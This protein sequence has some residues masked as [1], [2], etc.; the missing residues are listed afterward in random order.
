MAVDPASESP[1][2]NRRADRARCGCKI[3]GNSDLPN[4]KPN[5]FFISKGP[6]Q[7]IA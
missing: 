7:A 5:R 3:F 4:G 1:S 2:E 6:K